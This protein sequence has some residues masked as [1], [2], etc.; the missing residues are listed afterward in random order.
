M[1]PGYG[2]RCIREHRSGCWEVAA[3]TY[4]LCWCAGQAGEYLNGPSM[5]ADTTAQTCPPAS[6]TPG[7]FYTI[8]A[9]RSYALGWRSI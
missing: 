1:Q 9:G 7:S 8:K 4:E 6:R 5:N 3:G 2:A